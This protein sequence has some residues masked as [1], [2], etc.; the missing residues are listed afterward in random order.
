MSVQNQSIMSPPNGNHY[1]IEIVDPIVFDSS[2]SKT[3]TDFFRA[4]G[5][6]VVEGVSE[7]PHRKELVKRIDEIVAEN[8]PSSRRVGFL[9]LYH[10]DTLAQLRQNPN[11]YEVFTHLFETKKLWVVFDRVIYQ[12]ADEGEDPLNPHVDQNPLNHPGFSNI[13]AMIALKDMDEESGT[14]ALMPLSHHFFGEYAKW[15]KPEDGYIEYQGNRDLSFI[16]LRLKEG[17]MVLWDSRTT[18]G[19]FRGEAKRDRYAALVTFIKAKDDKELLDLRLKSFNEGIGVNNH[20]AGMRA[21]ARPRCEQ[22]LRRSAEK[23]SDLG[24]KLY[25]FESWE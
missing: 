9:D 7:E 19:R 15:G 20:D 17:Q 1:P 8:I 24:R 22:S 2:D 14:L 6:V 11:V 3:M 25:G 23:L 4:N 13:Q 18:H 21:T 10:D 16:G 5:Y 12:R